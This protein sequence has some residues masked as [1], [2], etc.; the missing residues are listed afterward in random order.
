MEI[1]TTTGVALFTLQRSDAAHDDAFYSDS[2]AFMDTLLGKMK[3]P[4]FVGSQA[5]RIT[6][7]GSAA[8]DELFTDPFGRKWQM[9]QYPLG[10]ADSV[11]VA[12][13]LPTPSGYVGM[14]VFCQSAEVDTSAEKLQLLA[15][16]FQS[17]YEGTLPQWKAYLARKPL[18]AGDLRSREAETGRRDRLGFESPRLQAGRAARTC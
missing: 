10:Y 7:A 14:L 13:A 11:I 15:S 6:S 4:R 3:L 12:A 5:I 18:R 2:R 9:R 16:Y 8:R 1:R 17:P